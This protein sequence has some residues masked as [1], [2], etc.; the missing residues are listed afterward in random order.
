[1]AVTKF[2]KKSNAF[3]VNEIKTDAIILYNKVSQEDFFKNPSFRL[4]NRALL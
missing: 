2:Y 3:Y 4:I 1:M